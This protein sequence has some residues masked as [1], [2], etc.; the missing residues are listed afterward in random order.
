MKTVVPKAR[1]KIEQIRVDDEQG[2][3][4]WNLDQFAWG[5]GHVLTR[6]FPIFIVLVDGTLSAFYYAQP[7]VVIYPTTAHP[8]DW[9]PRQ[10]YEVSKLV[11]DVSKRTFGNPLW[12]VD[13]QTGLDPE[14]L[15]KVHLVRQPLTVYQ[16][17]D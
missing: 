17:P 12:L 11:V 4:M 5:C 15:R 7:Q 14:L 6:I 8:K 3:K 2:V 13:E 1:Y 16:V 9:T 10:F